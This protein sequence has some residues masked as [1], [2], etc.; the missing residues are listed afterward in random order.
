MIGRFAALALA[1]CLIAGPASAE[2]ERILDYTSEITVHADGDLTIVETIKV[3]VTGKQIKRGIYRDFPTD[4]TDSHGNRVRVGFTVVEVTRDGEPEPY[5]TERKGNGVRV[6]IGQKDII[7]TP[8]TYTYTLTY[9]T[10]RQLG[11]FDDFDELYFNA[12]GHGWVFAIERARAIVHLPTGAEVLSTTAYTGRQGE[13]GGD[14]TT[15]VGAGG[16]VVFETTRPL[17]PREGL[18][19]VVSWPKGFV[20]EPTVSEAAGNFLRDNAIILAGLIGVLVVIAYYLFAWNKVGRDPETGTIVPLFEPPEGFSPAATRFVMGMGFDKKVFTA[21]IVNMAV[22][23]YLTIEDDDGDFILKRRHE[24]MSALSRGEKKLARMLFETSSELELDNVNNVRIRMAIGRLRETLRAEFGK[25]HFM[26]NLGYFIPGALI[27]G[28]AM[29]AIVLSAQVPSGVVPLAVMS[30]FVISFFSLIAVNVLFYFLLKAPTLKGRAIMDQ[31]EGF[32]LYLSVAEKDRL[33][34]FHPPDTTP[35]V[36]EKFLPYALALDVENEWSENF[37]SAMAAASAER[38]YR[39]GWY[40]GR[41]WRRHGI[42]GIGSSLGGAFA[43]AVSSASTP[44]GSS[45]GGGGGGFSGGGGGGGGG[46][47]W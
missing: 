18:T 36:F 14:F 15:G 17:K 32:K 6:Y 31:I 23:G 43:D 10:D 16:A 21:A 47:G 22:K 33:E 19:I 4:Y 41:G 20:A 29:I 34:A 13:S 5:H 8:D 12:I 38:R 24:D 11:F 45:S 25:L 39:P 30:T 44:P 26:R 7:L 9:R 3:V 37:A 40:S 46:G 28:F 2:R 1:L 35:E 27:S 42:G